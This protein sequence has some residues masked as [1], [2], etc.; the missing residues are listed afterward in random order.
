MQRERVTA[1]HQ[2]GLRVLDVVRCELLAIAAQVEEHDHAVAVLH[3]NL[4]AC[5]VVT[6]ALKRRR[7]WPGRI[8]TRRM[9]TA[10]HHQAPDRAPAPSVN[11]QDFIAR[12]DE[13]PEAELE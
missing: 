7:N 3:S 8:F 2:V 4:E 6:A 13:D 9:L 10:L 12:L 11:W 1:Q 5:G